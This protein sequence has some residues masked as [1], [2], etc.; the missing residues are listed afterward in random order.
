MSACDGG[1]R[2]FWG[3]RLA[4]D[5]KTQLLCHSRNTTELEHSSL[6][7]ATEGQAS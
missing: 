4:S 5:E 6:E 2:G 3:E 7:E 1:S